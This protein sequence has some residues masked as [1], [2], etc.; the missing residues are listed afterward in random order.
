MEAER[1]V[2]RLEVMRNY[3]IVDNWGNGKTLRNKT[4]GRSRHQVNGLVLDRL[5]FRGRSNVKQWLEF[6]RQT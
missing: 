5:G 2:K 1:P 6:R 4:G 3:Q